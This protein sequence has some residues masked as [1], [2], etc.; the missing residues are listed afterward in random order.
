MNKLKVEVADTP[1]KREY[2]LMDRK[3]LANNQGMLFKFPYAHYLSFWMKNTY[4]PLDI[5]FLDDNGRVLQIETM[6]PLSTRA[7]RCDHL[8][9]YALEVN[10][11]WFKQNNISVGSLIIGEG[12]THTKGRCVT[13]QGF[14]GKLKSV[15]D[16]WMKPKEPIDKVVS[17]KPEDKGKDKTEPQVTPKQ[18]DNEDLLDPPESIPEG[19]YPTTLPIEPMVQD[20]K[21]TV[22]HF[23]DMRGKIRFA[24]K[25]GFPMEIIYWTLKGHMLPP[26]KVQPIQ[27]EGYPIR[28]GKIGEYLVA[29]DISPTIT[30]GGGWTIKGMQPKSFIMDN[31]INLTLLDSNG[32][33]IPP[34][35]VERLRHQ[36][37][38]T[39]PQPQ[40]QQQQVPQQPQLQPQQTAPVM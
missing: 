5:A 38:G 15:W 39:Q 13:A 8:S 7:I 20:E 27:G 33:E 2:G 29:F 18:N 32:K 17:K 10:K 30:G 11:G 9:K 40:Q 31:I 6:S 22:E 4:I 34:E 14:M 28:M 12:L 19:E 16:K 24:E 3:V 35:D 26:R 36:E 25:H 21:S 37:K 1:T 23:R